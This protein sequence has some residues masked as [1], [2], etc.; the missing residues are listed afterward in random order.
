MTKRRRCPTPRKI[1]HPDRAAAQRHANSL[2]AAEGK[3]AM[4]HVYK[5]RCGAW[6]VGGRRKA[7]GRRR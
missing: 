6:H 2:Y 1:A 5:C 7:R 3:V 4:V